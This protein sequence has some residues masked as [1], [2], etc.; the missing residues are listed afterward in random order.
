MYSTGEYS[1]SQTTRQRCCFRR[2]I[3]SSQSSLARVVRDFL[4]ARGLMGRFMNRVRCFGRQKVRAIAARFFQRLLLAPAANLFVVA[5]DQNFRHRPAAK[6][7]GA[8]V[9]GKVEEEVT[10]LPLTR[11]SEAV[12]CDSLTADAGTPGISSALKRF[13]DRGI[14]VA[15]APGIRRVTASMTSAAASSPPESTKS[16]ME[17]SSVARCSAT[18]S[19]TPS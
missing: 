11:R 6:F 15:S 1:F 14:F 17:S 18:R 9:V 13:V 8:R 3:T 16:P 2:N 5:A 10:G 7:C 19:S 4:S 12:P